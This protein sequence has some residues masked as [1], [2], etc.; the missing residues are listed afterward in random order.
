[1]VR[2]KEKE[3]VLEMEKKIQA[4]ENDRDE[5]FKKRNLK[6]MEKKKVKGQVE[7]SFELGEKLLAAVKEGNFALIE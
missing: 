1:M 4:L 7:L 5:L 2:Q 6:R 3:Y